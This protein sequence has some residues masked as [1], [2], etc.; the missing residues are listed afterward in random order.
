MIQKD[1][2]WC[3]KTQNDKKNLKWCRKNWN[4]L[5]KDKL[6]DA[7]RLKSMQLKMMQEKWSKDVKKYQ[8]RQTTP[9]IVN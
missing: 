2:I 1:L 6:K 5:E 8:K 4:D 7:E 9:C 3:R